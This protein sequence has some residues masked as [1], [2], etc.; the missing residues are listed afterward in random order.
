M[1]LEIES[2][3]DFESRVGAYSAMHSA[4]LLS[5]HRHCEHTQSEITITRMA[6]AL[7]ADLPSSKS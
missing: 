4:S 1:E 3:V 5:N 7:E 6:E 2:C